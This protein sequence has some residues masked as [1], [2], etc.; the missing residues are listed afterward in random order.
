MTFSFHKGSFTGPLKTMH[1]KGF[2]QDASNALWGM[3][4]IW[5]IKAEYRISYLDRDYSTVIIART[6][7]DYVWIM[8]RTPQLGAGQY[9]GLVKRVGDLGYDLGKLRKVPQ[10]CP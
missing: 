8:S 5:P 7:R 3:Q 4:F 10:Q 1:P 9:D 6:A 2:V